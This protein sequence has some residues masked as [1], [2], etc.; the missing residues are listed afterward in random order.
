MANENSD[1]DPGILKNVMSSWWSLASSGIVGA[2]PNIWEGT[3]PKMAKMIFGL[4]KFIQMQ[5]R[6]P[7]KGSFSR[8][9]GVPPL[10]KWQICTPHFLEMLSFLFPS[11]PAT[12]LEQQVCYS[13]ID[14]EVRHLIGL[15]DFTD[16]LSL[17]GQ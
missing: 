6:A 8:C 7:S 17:A 2:I 15:R 16:Q 10:E 11:S 5:Q 14:G 12:I 4:I 3:F 13:K 1:R 9:L